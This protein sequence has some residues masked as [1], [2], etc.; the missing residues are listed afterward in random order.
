MKRLLAIL[1]VLAIVAGISWAVDFGGSTVVGA[2]ANADLQKIEVDQEIDIDIGPLHIDLAGGVDYDSMILGNIIVG[3]V[4]ADYEIGAKVGFSIFSV[5]GSIAGN[6]GV[7]MTDVKAFLDI[8]AGPVGADVDVLLSADSENDVFR[9][10]EFSA[11]WNPGPVELRIGY[12][13]TSAGVGEINTTEVFDDGGFYAT[14]K[15]SY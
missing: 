7:S 3:H 9:G 10:A 4:S 8:A 6:D 15:I 1:V 14:A 2:A 11:F 5:G 12:L 13:L